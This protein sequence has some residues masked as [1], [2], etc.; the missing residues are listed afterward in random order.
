MDGWRTVVLAIG[1]VL[2]SAGLVGVL[3][4]EFGSRQRRIVGRVRDAVEV[5][6]PVAG[7]IALLVWLW[8]AR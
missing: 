2:V 5:V 1:T 7:G 8:A 4:R 3:W 6:L